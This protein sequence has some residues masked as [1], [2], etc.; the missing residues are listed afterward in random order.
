MRIGELAE[1]T[2]VTTKT[3]R[4]YEGIGLLPEPERMANGYRSYGDRA[5]DRLHF[6]KDAQSAGLSLVEINLILD[7]RD[8]G[9]STCGH[10][11]S[12]LESHLDDIDLQLEEL[13]RTR[14]RLVTLTDRA[15]LLDPADCSDPNRC[16][17]IAVKN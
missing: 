3:I 17:T 7:L 9:Q 5:V 2:G 6:V 13:K 4:Y 16:Q 1:Q 15:R 11:I 10:V 8:G 14:Q 12:M